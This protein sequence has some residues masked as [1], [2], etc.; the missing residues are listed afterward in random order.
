M[1]KFNLK[2]LMQSQGIS[3]TDLATKT[4]LS[5]KAL[6]QLANNDSKGIQLSTL[7]SLMNFFK[8]NVSD[9]I[10]RAKDDIEFR[11]SQRPFTSDFKP[12]QKF[13]PSMSFPTLQ[14]FILVIDKNTNASF[15]YPV[16]STVTTNGGYS[17]AFFVQDFENINSKENPETFFAAQKALTVLSRSKKVEEAFLTHLVHTTMLAAKASNNFMVFD[18]SRS[19][20]PCLAALAGETMI[21][22]FSIK[23]GRVVID[24]D[25]LREQPD[26]LE[27][28]KMVQV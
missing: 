25:L 13:N 21:K 6:S 23:D 20:V 15:V 28:V 11:F 12:V 9:I 22:N 18:N 5:R 26:P 1:L 19:V 8:K 7:E 2:Q 27:S 3:I 16:M 10:V 17:I 4:G 24:D 14:L